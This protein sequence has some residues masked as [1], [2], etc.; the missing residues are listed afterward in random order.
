M[1]PVLG[2]DAVYSEWAVWRIEPEMRKESWAP[3]RTR[4]DALDELAYLQLCNEHARMS[5]EMEELSTKIWE[6]E[7]LIYPGANCVYEW[8]RV[9]NHKWCIARRKVSDWVRIS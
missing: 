3:Y 2:E 1:T 6:E 5:A 7:G 8:N 4:A 9:K